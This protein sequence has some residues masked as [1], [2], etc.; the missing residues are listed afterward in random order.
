MDLGRYQYRVNKLAKEIKTAVIIMT[1]VN[2]RFTCGREMRGKE[3]WGRRKRLGGGV[4][5]VGAGRG[6][7]VGAGGWSWIS[8]SETKPRSD[9][10]TSAW[11]VS[12]IKPMAWATSVPPA[13]AIART[14]K[15]GGR[16]S[17]LG[18]CRKETL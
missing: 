12:E 11:G 7:I 2:L 14:V 4:K 17:T 3:T 16:I 8:T 18:K 15:S 13:R 5:A 10:V 9:G 6:E 1:A